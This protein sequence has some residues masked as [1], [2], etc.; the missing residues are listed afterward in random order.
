MISVEV[1]V[2]GRGLHYR[3]EYPSWS[4][5]CG[6]NIIDYRRDG[7]KAP[8]WSIKV[9]SE[10]SGSIVAV[11]KIIL[12][13]DPLFKSMANRTTQIGFGAFIYARNPLKLCQFP[14]FAL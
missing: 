8:C 9:L 5:L 12:R 3:I 2:V 1:E 10:A 11:K 4:C 7:C 14:L 13:R 6:C